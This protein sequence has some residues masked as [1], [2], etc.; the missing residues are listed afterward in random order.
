MAYDPTLKL[1]NADSCI[2]HQRPRRHSICASQVNGSVEHEQCNNCLAM[3]ITFK[4]IKNVDGELK[5]L[6]D[7]RIVEPEFTSE[8]SASWPNVRLIPAFKIS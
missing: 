6:T 8:M 7:T 4:T 3:R 2:E 5:I 1:T